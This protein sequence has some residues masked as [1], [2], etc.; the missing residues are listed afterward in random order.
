MAF[1]TF[2]PGDVSS[3][4]LSNASLTVTNSVP[5]AVGGARSADKLI[6]GS[7]YIEYTLNSFGGAYSGIGFGSQFAALASGFKSASSST[8]T[9]GLCQDGYVYVNGVKTPVWFSGVL[10]S[11]LVIGVAFNIASGLVWFR[12]GAGG[13]WNN[14]SSA[15]PVAGIGGVPVAGLGEGFPLFAMVAVY[16]SGE[17]VTANFGN[18]AFVGAVPSGYTAGFV[19]GVTP[20]TSM[21]ATQVAVEE[22]TPVTATQ[23][24]VTQVAVEEWGPVVVP[25]VTIQATWNADG[26]SSVMWFG[27]MAPGTPPLPIP[28]AS[29]N[30]GWVPHGSSDYLYAWNT[31]LPKGQAW[32]RD[33]DSVQQMLWAGLTQYWGDVDANAALLLTTESDPRKTLMLLP[34]W[35]HA[36][37][38]PDPCVTAPQTIDAR[39][40]ALIAKMTLLGCQSR[41]CLIN[42]AAELGYTITI[43]EYSPYICGVSRVGD[44]IQQDILAGGDGTHYRWELGPPEMRFIWTVHLGASPYTQ[45]HCAAGQCGLDPEGR[46]LAFAVDTDLECILNR[47]KPAQTYIAFDYTGLNQ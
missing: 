4:T 37:G 32:N 28:G 31:L 23:I 46:L 17:Q 22:W 12:I 24:Q 14:T 8:G 47:Y 6:T 2:N 3:A 19:T 18:S 44:T 42:Y 16:G 29:L 26:I 21:A 9:V 11:G 5:A 45:F 1:T 13:W 10:V 40:A 41:Q 38:L 30:D 35:E 34:D 33:F 43:S 27:G 7:C 25:P 36:W 39:R 20:S 15:D